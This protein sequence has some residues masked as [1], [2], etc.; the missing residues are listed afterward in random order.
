MCPAPLKS[1][2]YG[3]IQICLLLFIIIIIMSKT[4][5][6]QPQWPLRSLKVMQLIIDR[7]NISETVQ[8][9]V[10]NCTVIFLTMCNFCNSKSSVYRWYSQLDRRRF[11]YHTY[12]T[13]KATRTRHG[14]VHMF[15]T[16]RPTSTLQLHNFDLF[17]TCRTSSF[18]TVVWQL[19]RFQLT[20][21]ITR[22]L[23]VSWVSCFHWQTQQLI[24]ICWKYQYIKYTSNV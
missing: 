11:V 5:F 3:A 2:P 20:Q 10:N 6:Q 14:W 7:E 15:I 12:K 16:H 21:R 13:M 18:C 23:G 22:S 4:G 24:C 9:I 19:A 8:N 1:R 17:R